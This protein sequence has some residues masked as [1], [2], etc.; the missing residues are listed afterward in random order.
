[1]LMA[2]WRQIASPSAKMES[3]HRCKSHL[4]PAAAPPIPKRIENVRFWGT[5]DIGLRGINVCFW[6]KTDMAIALRMSA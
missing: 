5:T 2:H 4:F 3:L 6:G 1:M